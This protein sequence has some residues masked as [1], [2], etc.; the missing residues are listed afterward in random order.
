MY[1]VASPAERRR[2][3]KRCDRRWKE[4]AKDKNAVEYAL[5]LLRSGDA[6]PKRVEDALNAFGEAR[7]REEGIERAESFSNEIKAEQIDLI[8]QVCEASPEYLQQNPNG[9][10]RVRNPLPPAKPDSKLLMGIV[11]SG[12]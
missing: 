3:L 8:R 4:L 1:A 12:L 5:H 11:M 7:S 6:P 9:T 10:W 2:I